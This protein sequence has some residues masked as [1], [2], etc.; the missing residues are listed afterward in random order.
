M[1]SSKM[2]VVLALVLSSLVHFELVFMCGVRQGYNFILLNPD[3]LLTPY[4]LKEL[5]FFSAGLS[6]KTLLR[7]SWPEYEGLFLNSEFHLLNYVSILIYLYHAALITV[8]LEYVLKSETLSP[9]ILFFFLMDHLRFHGFRISLSILT[10]KSLERQSQVDLSVLLRPAWST[11][12]VPSK[13]G[14]CS[15]K[16]REWRTEGGRRKKEEK[17]EKGKG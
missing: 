1:F 2:F 4:S 5:C 12:G 11:Q 10:K 13:P 8:D 9:I 16:E 7:L 6:Q 14:L 17:A 3:I 15:E